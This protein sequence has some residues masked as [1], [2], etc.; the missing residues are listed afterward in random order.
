MNE[1]GRD[2]L[3]LGIGDAAVAAVASHA[4][5]LAILHHHLQAAAHGAV[6]ACDLMFHTGRLLTVS[7]TRSRLRR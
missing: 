7:R 6:D 3:L 5:D 4:L 1:F 2:A